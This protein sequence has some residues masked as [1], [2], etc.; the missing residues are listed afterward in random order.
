M[1]R[2]F[3][4]SDVFRSA[5]IM[6]IACAACASTALA[7]LG[8]CYINITVTCCSVSVGGQPDLLY[9][10]LG[11]ACPDQICPGS[12]PTIPDVTGGSPGRQKVVQVLGATATCQWCKSSCT[13]VGGSCVLC[14]TPCASLAAHCYGW[15]NSGNPC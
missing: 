14:G 2:L 13:G 11:N 12:N 15:T 4:F 3:S 6:T 1:Q 5:A 10:C 9:N 7:T 8:V